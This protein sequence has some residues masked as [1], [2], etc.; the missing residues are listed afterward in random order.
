MK[1]NNSQEQIHT[2]DH[3][4]MATSFRLT[5]EGNDQRY[6]RQAAL[7]VF[8]LLDMFESKWSRFIENSDISRINQ[9]DAGERT[10]VHPSTCDCLRLALQIQAETTGAFDIAYATAREYP[11][12][13]PI[14]LV[15]GRSVVH[16]LRPQPR[17]DLG[18]I[19]KGFAL[20][21][22]GALLNKWDVTRFRLQASQSTFLCGRAPQDSLGWKVHIGPPSKG[23]SAV[24]TNAAI[25]GSGNAVKGPHIIDPRVG[26]P[27]HGRS[28]AWATAS[29]A[30]RADALST[31]FMIMPESRIREYCRSHPQA[32]AAVASDANS[33]PRILARGDIPI[34]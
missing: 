28:M 2:M 22:M 6:A 24:L 27:V 19:G 21:R 16:V 32:F 31:A 30:A 15:P 8:Q 13:P 9:L 20:D 25:S 17:L 12:T 5:I 34:S 26:T 11:R 10:I 18:G 3:E 1:R 29:E 7:E 14:S 4:A 23:L 33:N